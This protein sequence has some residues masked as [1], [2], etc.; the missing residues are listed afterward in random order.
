M[1]HTNT[2]HHGASWQFKT[3]NILRQ[4]VAAEVLSGDLTVI[5]ASSWS[6]VTT[7]I[8]AEFTSHHFAERFK[9]VAARY[10][11]D[12]SLVEYNRAVWHVI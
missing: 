3:G 8:S 2:G 6:E 12:S 9:P 7:Q 1:P 5:D 10:G 11:A 4:K